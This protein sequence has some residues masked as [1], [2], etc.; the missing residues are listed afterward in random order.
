MP[1]AGATFVG[2]YPG[3]KNVLGQAER[4]ADLKVPDQHGRLVHLVWDTLGRCCVGKYL[5]FRV[6]WVPDISY[7]KV[8]AHQ[9]FPTAVEWDYPQLLA[10][11]RNAWERWFQDLRK[12]ASR[13]NGVSATEAYAA[14]REGR[15]SEVPKALLEECGITPESEDLIKAAMA[16]NKWVLGFS[17]VVPEWA[18][19]LLALWEAQ[20]ARAS[21]PVTDAELAKFRDAVEEDV[22]L[23]DAFDPD[24][25]GGHV[26]PVRAKAA[27][28]AP[29]LKTG[30]TRRE[31]RLAGDLTE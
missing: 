30:K 27:E 22:D 15:W 17:T 5:L 12:F 10:D 2:D 7:A 9:N 23:D 24:A 20:K 1:G 18:S 19:P 29:R 21:L 6:P 3:K 13:M 26:V 4:R 16:G 8:V 28:A 31:V 25:R 14:A 11:T